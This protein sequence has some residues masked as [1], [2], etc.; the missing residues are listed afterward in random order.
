M[1]HNLDVTCSFAGNFVD[2]SN[3][4]AALADMKLLGSKYGTDM[5]RTHD[6]IDEV[7]FDPEDEVWVEDSL[8]P[9]Q[10]VVRY[11]DYAGGRAGGWGAND[12][13]GV[14]EEE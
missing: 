12:W 11:E 8:T 6:A 14:P 1:V 7:W 9:R 2:E 4:D 13:D 10:L 5:E 3:L